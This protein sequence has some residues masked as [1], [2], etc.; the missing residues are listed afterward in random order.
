MKTVFLFLTNAAS[1][2]N[3]K[4]LVR[5]QVTNWY[6]LGLQLNIDDWVLQSIEF[7]NPR[8]QERCMRA[9]FRTW[10]KSCPQASY[11]D[12]VQAMIEMGEELEADRLCKEYGKT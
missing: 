10:P 7:N 5:V 12:L 4:E 11:R 9:V 3:P 6:N 8:D 1:H 2:P